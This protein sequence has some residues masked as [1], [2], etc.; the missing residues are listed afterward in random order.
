MDCLPL[1][2]DIINKIQLYVSTP[3][4]DMIRNDIPLR[5]SRAI[6][7]MV[8]K[9]WWDYKQVFIHAF[10]DKW[11]LYLRCDRDGRMRKLYE[12]QK[13]V[14]TQGFG[15]EIER[16]VLVIIRIADNIFNTPP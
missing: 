14:I 16:E 4:A 3:E 7:K 2:T 11:R 10:Q 8:K 12:R 1:P 15:R 13:R 5:H 6:S 9:H